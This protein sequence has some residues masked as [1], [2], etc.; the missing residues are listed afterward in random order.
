MRDVVDDLLA[1]WVVVPDRIFELV[2][3]CAHK[4]VTLECRLN[5]QKHLDVA[6]VDASQERQYREFLR[7]QAGEAAAKLFQELQSSECKVLIES[8]KQVHGRNLA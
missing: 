7:V 3:K 4:L 5:A 2:Q 8:L 1:Q 6:I